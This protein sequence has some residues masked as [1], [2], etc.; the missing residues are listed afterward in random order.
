LTIDAIRK[1]VGT[2]T[3]QA[4]V[5][6]SVDE[7]LQFVRYLVDPRK[8]EGQR[9]AMTLAVEGESRIRRIELRN[10]VLVISDAEAASPVHVALTRQQL[11][12]FVLGTRAPSEADPLGRLDRVLDRSHL[13]PP[14]TVESVLQG[15]QA[16]DGP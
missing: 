10:G 12:A 6:A 16:G 9:L 2:P 8:A 4:L 1:F 3:A 14:G 13:L 5:A 15:M 7:N 11:A